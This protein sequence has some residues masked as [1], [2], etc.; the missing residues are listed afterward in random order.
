MRDLTEGHRSQRAVGEPEQ[1]V[2]V[3]VQSPAGEVGRQL[4]GDLHGPQS[5]DVP[6]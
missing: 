5:R 2:S 3:V 6:Q 1:G 4:A